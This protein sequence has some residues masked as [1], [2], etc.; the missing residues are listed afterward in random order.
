[1]NV[2]ALVPKPLDILSEYAFPMKKGK[3]FESQKQSCV[4][5]VN[6]PRGYVLNDVGTGKTLI[7]LWAY[8]Y[9]RSIGKA[10]IM[11][12][13]APL[14]TLE[15]RWATELLTHFPHLRFKILHGTREQRL[16]NLARK[17]INVFIINHHGLYV[18]LDELKARKDIDNLTG[19]S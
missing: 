9:L 7:P 1:M 8:D 19:N 15:D 17:N 13:V 12:V 3:P 14:S 5:A 4:M 16:V 18:I 11:L 2:A 6:D 10:T